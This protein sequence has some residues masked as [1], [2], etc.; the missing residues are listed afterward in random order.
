MSYQAALFQVKTLGKGSC[1]SMA[2]TSS[3]SIK[4][5]L[6]LFY[7]ELTRSKGSSQWGRSPLCP[8]QHQGRGRAARLFS[9]LQAGRGKVQA[10]PPPRAPTRLSP[11]L[12]RSPE[13]GGQLGVPRPKRRELWPEERSLTGRGLANPGGLTSDLSRRGLPPSQLDARSPADSRTGPVPPADTPLGWG[14]RCT[15]SGLLQQRAAGTRCNVRGPSG[16]RTLPSARPYPSLCFSSR[17]MGAASAPHTAVTA[18]R[19]SAAAAASRLPGAGRGRGHPLPRPPAVLIPRAARSRRATPGRR[20]AC[21]A[22]AE[23]RSGQG[24]RTAH[25]RPSTEATEQPGPP[26][27]AAGAPPASGVVV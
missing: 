19:Q 25:S 27:S 5:S 3:C 18:S 6:L 26:P 10:V 17:L 15:S 22:R 20:G 9:C 2:D 14:S 21:R 12:A 16:R 7:H 4:P 13:P 11:P 23:A 24:L 1:V 8:L